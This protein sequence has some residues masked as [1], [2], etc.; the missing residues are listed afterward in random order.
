MKRIVISLVA[1]GA[2]ALALA[3]PARAEP[4]F[5]RRDDGYRYEYREHRYRHAWEWRRE[6]EWRELARARR[7]FYARW[8]GNPWERARFER[9]YA[10]RCEELRRW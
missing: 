2:A 3:S 6:R 5:D 10:H 9:W 4:R 8:D 1:A 7:L